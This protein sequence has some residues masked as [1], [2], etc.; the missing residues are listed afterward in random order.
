MLFW[1]LIAL[2]SA[3]AVIVLTY[4]FLSTAKTAPVHDALSPARAVY[5]AQLAELERE[6]GLGAMTT[7]ELDSAKAELGRRLLRAMKDPANAKPAG[8]KP[9]PGLKWA[10]VALCVIV[11]VGALAIYLEIGSPGAPSQIPEARQAALAERQQY[12]NLVAA[13]ESALQAGKG[14]AQGWRMLAQGYRNLNE[15]A[16][17]LDALKRAG[18][19]MKAKGQD[20]PADILAALGSG[21]VTE[22]QGTV[23]AAALEP[24]RAALAIEPANMT[25]RFYLGLERAQNADAKGARGFWSPLSAELPEGTPLRVDL[26]ERLKRLPADKP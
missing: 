18:P 3:V 6:A 2:I 26:E 4:P 15:P 20:V 14:D 25:A 11:P 19:W 7:A 22:A 10:A 23:T 24:L 8:T 17:A 5:D 21:L 1:I 9:E 12:A 13:L 16:K